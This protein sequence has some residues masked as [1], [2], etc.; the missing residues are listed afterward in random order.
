MF[1]IRPVITV[2]CV[3]HIE[4]VSYGYRFVKIVFPYLNDIVFVGC[5]ITTIVVVAVM[6]R[7]ADIVP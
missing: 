7:I 3:P 6:A 2:C 5:S 4:R 1:R